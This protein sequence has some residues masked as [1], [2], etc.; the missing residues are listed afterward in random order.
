MGDVKKRKQWRRIIIRDY[1]GAE[2][3][4]PP[5]PPHSF[6]TCRH[7][8]R[9]DFDRVWPDFHI[10]RIWRIII[11]SSMNYASKAWLKKHVL[12]FYSFFFFCLHDDIFPCACNLL[13]EVLKKIT[14]ECLKNILKTSLKKSVFC[15]GLYFRED[16]IFAN[17]A[18]W[19][20]REKLVTRIYFPW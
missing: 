12:F 15:K 4:L 17:F 5:N 11:L 3:R 14:R 10:K 18:T 7:A 8:A 6:K 16:L 1:P 19:K 2:R 9:G 13:L 20:H